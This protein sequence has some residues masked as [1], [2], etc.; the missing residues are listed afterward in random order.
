[1][2]ADFGQVVV[3]AAVEGDCRAVLATLASLPDGAKP[4][5]LVRAGFVRNDKRVSFV[6]L[7]IQLRDMRLLE[8]VVRQAPFG[9]TV[10]DFSHSMPTPGWSDQ[11]VFRF[12]ALASTLNA[13]PDGLRLAL[14]LE[15]QSADLRR[16]HARGT[17]SASLHYISLASAAGMGQRA[18]LLGHLEC[19]AL[20]KAHCAPVL[21][22]GVD[23]AN[24]AAD[25]LFARKWANPIGPEL[26][27]FVNSYVAA[28]LLRLDAPLRPG[29]PGT[30][31]MLPLA[32]AMKNG[33]SHGAR[34]VILA[35]CD[36]QA[37]LAPGF[38]DVLEMAQSYPHPDGIK[39]ELLARMTEALM[40]RRVA[41]SA[42][43]EKSTVPAR[44]VK[45]QG[46]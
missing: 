24:P 31:G 33:C 18:A 41:S 19:A 34:A 36:V 4:R 9:L 22:A 29:H 38:T 8:H 43:P 6:D 37:A 13:Y 27:E 3:R 32:A 15:P 16:L 39:A 21:D 1:M 30:G 14:R 35:G 44:R 12:L 20:L 7:C 11:L 2:S 46:L 25:A 40:L 26:S 5:E 23:C 28:G 42:A 45:R 10:T 17:S